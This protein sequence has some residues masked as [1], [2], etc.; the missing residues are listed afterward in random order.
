MLEV[1]TASCGREFQGLVVI[2]YIKPVFYRGPGVG[3]GSNLV[4]LG[5]GIHKLFWVF[6]SLSP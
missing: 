1:N 6:A 3:F 2:C 4:S 5:W